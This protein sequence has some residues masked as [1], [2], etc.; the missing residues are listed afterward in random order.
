[1]RREA[2]LLISELLPLEE[3]AFVAQLDMHLTDDQKVMVQI[4]AVSGNILS[5][6]LIKTY[7]Q[8]GQQKNV[9]KYLLV[10]GLSLSGKKVVR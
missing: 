3:S 7:F 8:G 4:P 10:R 9:H 1:M 5:W 6:R 2:N